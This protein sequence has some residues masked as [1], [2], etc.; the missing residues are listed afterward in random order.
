VTIVCAGRGRNPQRDLLNG[1][2]GGLKLPAA[3]R[4]LKKEDDEKMRRC[5][6]E[7]MM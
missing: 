4:A 6:G 7:K 3:G 1:D 2:A 5:V